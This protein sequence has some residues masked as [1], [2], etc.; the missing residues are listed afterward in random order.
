MDLC[1]TDAYKEGAFPHTEKIGYHTIS[2]P[3][4]PA[5]TFSQQDNVIQ[6]LKTLLEKCRK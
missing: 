3:L 1:F 2:L 4:F 6:Q 5:L